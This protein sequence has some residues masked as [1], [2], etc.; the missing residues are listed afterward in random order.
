MSATARPSN[1]PPMP[2][3]TPPLSS[4]KT[5]S[6]L[7][8]RKSGENSG[9]SKQRGAH[10]SETGSVHGTLSPTT[11]D[12][13]AGGHL[14]PSSEES[15]QQPPMQTD[16]GNTVESPY[17]NK[18]E[19]SR[20]S[21]SCGSV[22]SPT[23]DMC[24]PTLNVPVSSRSP[25]EAS[26]FDATTDSRNA[27]ASSTSPSTEKAPT[28]PSD[29]EDLQASPD[30][31]EAAQ[32][33]SSSTENA[34]MNSLASVDSPMVASQASSEFNA[35]SDSD[36]EMGDET[37]DNVVAENTKIL[38]DSLSSVSD[39]GLKPWT[40]KTRKRIDYS[41]TTKIE[42]PDDQLY[43][44]TASRKRQK[45]ETSKSNVAETSDNRKRK[46]KAV[47]DASSESSRGRESVPDLEEEGEDPVK[48][49]LPPVDHLSKYTYDEDGHP[50][51]QFSV[52]GS[53]GKCSGFQRKLFI[54]SDHLTL[55]LSCI[56]GRHD[57]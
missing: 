19:S 14:D 43:L 53:D 31:S 38:I 21:S 17:L 34:S 56:V 26:H 13:G 49:C 57:L 6:I 54:L 50:T 32:S 33:R 2:K 9:P 7:R 25:T 5:K 51:H 45:A 1:S 39:E 15:S 47:S 36:S 30:S 35:P 18:D 27:F 23:E 22:V 29:T 46:R 28:H 8:D 41:D 48:A 11:L 52:L 20:N 12:K 10:G 40:R 37:E 16:L 44:D 55:S 24:D 3:R 4:G 42:T